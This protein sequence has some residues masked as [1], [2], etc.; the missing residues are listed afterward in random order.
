[1]FQVRSEQSVL[2]DAASRKSLQLRLLAR[3]RT[4][5]PDLCSTKTET[6]VLAGIEGS[7]RVAIQL[8]FR[9]DKALAQFASLSFLMGCAFWEIPQIKS[10]LS[11]GGMSA[12]HKLFLL[13]ERLQ[14]REG[15]FPKR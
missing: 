11:L 3:L 8:G 12:D 2:L 9:S 7:F 14:K 15:A 4:I 5:A 6:E 1:M 10:F 13:T